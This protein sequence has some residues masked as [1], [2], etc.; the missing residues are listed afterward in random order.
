M[1]RRPFWFGDAGVTGSGESSEGLPLHGQDVAGSFANGYHLVGIRIVFPCAERET[2][3]IN[4][5]SMTCE[6]MTVGIAKC[7][8]APGVAVQDNVAGLFASGS[9]LNVP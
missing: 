4:F 9:D 2:C 6:D 8:L 1:N 3:Q 7:E 5:R